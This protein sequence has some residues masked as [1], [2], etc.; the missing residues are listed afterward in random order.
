[1]PGPLAPFAHTIAAN[2]CAF[3]KRYDAAI[4][5]YRQVLA[6]EPARQE[7]WR[8][9]AFLCSQSNREPEAIEAFR[10]AIR[11][12]PSDATTRFNLGFLHHQ[13]GE[14]DA[15]L[16]QF[17]EVVKLAPNVDRA[18]YGAGLIHLD[19]GNLEAAIT[20]LAEAAR[21]QYFNPHAAHHLVIAYKRAGRQDEAIAELNRLN[22]F[23]P[24]AAKAVAAETGYRL[25]PKKA[26]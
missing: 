3:L 5:H 11:L 25:L 12:D 18:W 6:A 24:N 2:V 17:A 16:E 1:M 26:A 21:I 7:A 4:D 20:H 22:G 14:H 8:N 19:R 15:A 9:L 23:D 13:R 10:E